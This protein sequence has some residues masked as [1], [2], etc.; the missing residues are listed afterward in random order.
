M[1]HVGKYKVSI[2]VCG[3]IAA[4]FL[5]TLYQYRGSQ[6]MNF[7]RD[8]YARLCMR[9]TRQPLL[10]RSSLVRE[11]FRSMPSIVGESK[12][13]VPHA[14]AAYVRTRGTTMIDNLCAR[15]GIIPYYYQ[16][17][18][19]DVEHGRAGSRDY[20]WP[21][22]LMVE[23]SIH[24][25]GIND[26]VVM[27]DV[28]QYVDM[29]Y[30]LA[31]Y[32]RIYAIATVQPHTVG[33]CAKDYTYWFTS[34]SVLH[35][36]VAGG[37][38][39]VHQVWNYATD[40]ICVHVV[41]WL[42][43]HRYVFYNVEHRTMDVDHHIILLV[44]SY[45]MN[46]WIVDPGATIAT[47]LLS[48]VLPEVHGGYAAMRV[49]TENGMFVSIGKL[50]SPLSVNVSAAQYSGL[51]CAHSNYGKILTHAS[52]M[53]MVPGITDEQAHMISAYVAVKQG[54]NLTLVIRP[55]SRV[56]AYEPYTRKYSQA[57][58]AAMEPFMNP[59]C[60]GACVPIAS[61]A[62]DDFT[63]RER[64]QKVANPDAMSCSNWQA[65]V[66]R[67]FIQ[68]LIPQAHCLVPRD[69]EEV[70]ERQS[71]PTQQAILREG[72]LSSFEDEALM[73][74]SFMKKESYMKLNPPRNITTM[75]SNL[76]MLYSSFIYAFD[77][78][79]DKQHWY[80]FKRTPAEIAEKV[81]DICSA[82]IRDVAGTDFSK[83]DGRIGS[84]LRDLERA[85]LLRAFRPEYQQQVVALWKKQLKRDAT[86][87][88][89]SLYNTGYSRESGSP[90][91]ALFNS[92]DN[93]FIAFA[94]K[95][96]CGLGVEDA[97][98]QLGIY[99]GDDGLTADVDVNMYQNMAKSFGQ[100]LE[101]VVYQRGDSNVKFLARV[102]APDVW[103]GNCNSMCSLKRQLIKFHLVT[104]VALSPTDKLREKALSYA[105]SDANTP[106][107]GPL[108]V[109][110]VR[111]LGVLTHETM[112]RPYVFRTYGKDVQYPN[113][114][115][116]WMHELSIQE[117]SEFDH[118][119]FKAWIASIQ[120][121]EG[122]T[123][124]TAVLNNPGF[125]LPEDVKPVE[126]PMV[127]NGEIV[128]PTVV[129]SLAPV[130]SVPSL[131]IKRKPRRRVRAVA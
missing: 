38:H 45:S 56:V 128:P 97:W 33:F 69:C 3:V 70:F 10:T 86:T 60:A 1:L 4:V 5:K 123:F 55:I 20:R 83:M 18:K 12:K 48:R 119:G 25:P 9:L 75:P 19:C 34:D 105:Y 68:Q 64:I 67:E 130:V 63:V 115:E 42:C 81:R 22:D 126:I 32:P 36:F 8:W 129:A 73:L 93:A 107:L 24:D 47:R 91:T 17:A 96:Q 114:E 2:T 127:V 57:E 109:T 46:S 30:M 28:D 16:Q 44:P 72:D 62:N 117:L 80:A 131:K 98:R 49:Q 31:E 77:E 53:R 11:E 21:A 39:Y 74:R 122:E 87:E 65:E 54:E 103:D 76:K 113:R 27:V 7:Y 120:E 15:L 95:R 116:P 101:A 89:G 88:L 125:S 92:I 112:I 37:A 82:A 52:V 41:D 40:V 26:M 108:C 66:M 121:L 118:A 61:R 90:E 71:R 84:L 99:G 35:Y 51:L 111:K 59:L 102:Y 58:S 110:I 104:R 94:T 106:V 79:M 85:V 14:Q 23:P 50:E 124:A 6:L 29:N 78:I 100:K 13:T 43:R